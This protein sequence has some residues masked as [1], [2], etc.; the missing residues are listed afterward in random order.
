M[1]PESHP[2]SLARS[3]EGSESAVIPVSSLPRIPQSALR[4][5]FEGV[6]KKN[7]LYTAVQ[8]T[9]TRKAGFASSRKGG[10]LSAPEHDCNGY[11]ASSPL[12][13][14]RSSAQLFT[15][16]SDSTAKG[17][18]EFQS[19][20]IQETP[21]KRKEEIIYDHSHPVVI[22]PCSD[23]ENE[24]DILGRGKALVDSPGQEFGRGEESIYKSL[25][26]DD[27]VDDI[28]DLV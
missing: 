21:V 4:P 28:D 7:P 16:A 10:L 22:G 24:D 5:S 17:L 20:G 3:I 27:D 2:S 9:P 14:R 18:S 12:H 19:H 8:A 15:T 13:V 23:K 26:W 1:A 25:G 6:P 11:L